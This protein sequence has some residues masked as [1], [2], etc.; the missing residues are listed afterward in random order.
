MDWMM[1]HE[2][3]QEGTAD[4]KSLSS[5]AGRTEWPLTEMAEGQV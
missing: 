3:K 1:G 4:R 5:V 2:N